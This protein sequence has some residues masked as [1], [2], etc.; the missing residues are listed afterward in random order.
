MGVLIESDP[1]D[2]SCSYFELLALLS[3]LETD[4]SCCRYR[5]VVMYYS[6][7]CE[8]IP[9]ALQD[10]EISFRRLSLRT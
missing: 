7:D 8:F 2:M 10:V 9:N 6:P 4:N 1:S 3:P 5:G